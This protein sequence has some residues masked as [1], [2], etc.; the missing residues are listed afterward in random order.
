[1]CYKK[2][3]VFSPNK[4]NVRKKKLREKIRQNLSE[5]K[6]HQHPQV[7]VPVEV[8]CSW[9]SPGVPEHPQAERPLGGP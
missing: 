3:G 5:I 7:A 9:V 1:M 6:V 4:T 2:S 8:L